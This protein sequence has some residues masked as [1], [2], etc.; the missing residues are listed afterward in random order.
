MLEELAVYIKEAVDKKQENVRR[1]RRRDALRLQIVRL[2]EYIAENDTFGV[3]PCAIDKDSQGLYPCIVEFIEGVRYYLENEMDKNSSSVRDL[4]HHFCNFLRR[5]INNFSC[6]F[7]NKIIKLLRHKQIPVDVRRSLLKRDLRKSIFVLL[8]HWVG[9]YT[10]PNTKISQPDGDMSNKKHA[11]LQ[12]VCLQ[13]MSSLLCCGPCFDS[14]TEES[15]YY[16]WLDTLLN[17]ID[18]KVYN[19]AQETVIL[20]LESNP[21]VPQL[22]DWIVDKCYTGSSK[23]ADCCFLALATIF[24]ARFATIVIFR[25]GNCMS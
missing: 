11:D 4:T 22:L 8:T 21:D 1:R 15:P 25:C 10:L 18:D 24:S 12:F 2:L 7:F 23:V 16:L 20:L 9:K 14:L 19:L 13:A 6:K 5:M 3:S 17:S